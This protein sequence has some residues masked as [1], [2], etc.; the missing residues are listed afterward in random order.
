M[1]R[2]FVVLMAFGALAVGATASRAYVRSTT[3]TGTPVAWRERCRTLLIDSTENPEFPHDR[4]LRVV[5]RAVANWVEPTKECTAVAITVSVDA[6]D[7][8]EVVY[9]GANVLLWRLP[10]FC[11]DQDNA[12]AEVC[13]APNAAA[14]TTIFYYDKPGDS[15]DG[16][17]LE[18]DLVINA[19]GFRF[20]EGSA[21]SVDLE[22]VL[23]HELGHFL[24]LGHTCYNTFGA[25]P[26]LDVTG[27]EVPFCF[28]LTALDADATEATMFTY[29]DPGEIG[30][31][32]PT[33]DEW[34]GIC[35]IY[36]TT[37]GE[38]YTPDLGGCACQ[39]TVEHDHPS[40]LAVLA[41][42]WLGLLCLVR[43]LIKRKRR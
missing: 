39:A 8:A 3:S 11:D 5:D 32:D 6:V 37:P 19:E 41:M 27:E 30:K 16:E 25:V 21:D 31:R 42:C 43:P 17:L 10:G 13:L 4:L 9:D 7:R 1:R 35:E 23:T 22:A 38:C 12:L 28:P 15:E 18:A 36:A 14:I 2:N 34:K 40:G 33:E 20:D 26:P 29:I 24:G